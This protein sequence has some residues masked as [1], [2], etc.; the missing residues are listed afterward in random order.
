MSHRHASI[1]LF[2]VNPEYPLLKEAVLPEK[3]SRDLDGTSKAA[4]TKFPLAK[5]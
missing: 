2:F 3:S 4:Q 1:L 5:R